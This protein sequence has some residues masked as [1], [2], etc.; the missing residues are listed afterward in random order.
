MIDQH[1]EMIYNGT[2]QIDNCLLKKKKTPPMLYTSLCTGSLCGIFP[3]KRYGPQAA[4]KKY[5]PDEMYPF[6]CKVP[7]N[8]FTR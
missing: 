3:V 8:I 1:H 5:Y 6:F 4:S 7:F 2:V